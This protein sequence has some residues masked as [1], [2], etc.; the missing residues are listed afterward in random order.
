MKLNLTTSPNK[1]VSGPSFHPSPKLPSPT[2][3]VRKT[4]YS[5]GVGS[6]EGKSLLN[7]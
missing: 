1:Q 5:I 7:I 6:Q 2:S 3:Y 4:L